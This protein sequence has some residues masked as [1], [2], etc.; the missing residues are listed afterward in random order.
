MVRIGFRGLTVLITIAAIAACGSPAP[1]TSDSSDPTQPSLIPAATATPSPTA[2]IATVRP[3]RPTPRPSGAPREGALPTSA[4][5]E[6]DGVK[7]TV[8]LG[9]SNPMHAGDWSPA[10]VTIENTGGR[11]LRWSNDGCDTNAGISATMLATW[12]DSAREVAP[13]LEPYRERLRL[14]ARVDDPIGLRFQKSEFGPFRSYGCADLAIARELAPGR[15]VTQELVWDGFAAPRLGLPPSGPVTLTATFGRWTRPGP[16]NDGDPIVVTLESW[17]LHG[18]PDE[19]L[20]PA[21]AIDAALAD[22]RLAA[23]LV[24]RSLAGN[25]SGVAEYDADLDLWAV[26]LLSYRDDGDPVLHAALVDPIT[27]E[28]IAIRQHRVAF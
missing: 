6:R 25:A 27:G 22:E 10:F 3:F 1:T 7:L 28:V 12:R 24:T 18:R 4:S 23:W 16:G 17:V 26:G 14:E 9:G 15:S 19:Y 5:T 21:E 13:E 8:R 20:S 2:A 11:L